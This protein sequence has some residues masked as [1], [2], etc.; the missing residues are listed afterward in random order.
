MHNPPGEVLYETL[1]DAALEFLRAGLRVHFLAISTLVLV[2]YDH[3]L[4]FEPE[5]S[6]MLSAV[7]RLVL[8]GSY[9]Y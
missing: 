4:T 1:A 7:Y 2:L 3:C 8:I 5:V 9:V 6:L